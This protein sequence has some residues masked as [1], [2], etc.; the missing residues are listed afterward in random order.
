MS[1]D[2]VLIVDDAA[3]RPAYADAFARAGWRVLEA[4]TGESAVEIALAE[5]PVAIIA[6]YPVPV[7]NTRTT[8]ERTLRDRSPDYRPMLVAHTSWAWERV[9]RQALADGYQLFV[10]KPAEPEDL[11]EAVEDLV[12]ASSLPPALEV[13]AAG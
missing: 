8:V 4:N 6:A 1:R 7:G 11:R 13:Q 5:R 3:D 9:R 2:T 12:S 10:E